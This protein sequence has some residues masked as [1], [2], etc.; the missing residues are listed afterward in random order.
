MSRIISISDDVYQI[1]TRLKNK[2]S[3]SKIIRN[4]LSKET[5]KEKL[6]V[7]F[8]KGGVD[9]GVGQRCAKEA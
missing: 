3:Y 7:F 2:D 9:A 8:G 6:L 1:L 5:N 4:L